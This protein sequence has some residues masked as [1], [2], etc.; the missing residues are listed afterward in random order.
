MPNLRLAFSRTLSYQIKVSLGFL[1][2]RVCC[3][4]SQLR[5]LI[6]GSTVTQLHGYTNKN[7]SRRALGRALELVTGKLAKEKVVD[8]RGGRG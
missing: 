5:S 8:L 4:H 6:A 2:A 3:A 7:H 1:Q